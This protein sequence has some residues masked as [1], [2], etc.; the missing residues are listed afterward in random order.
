MVI[1][2]QNLSR[3]S[4]TSIMKAVVSSATPAKLTRRK[5]NKFE[6]EFR[7]IAG[8]GG[9]NSRMKV[10]NVGVDSTVGTRTPRDSTLRET[11]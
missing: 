5:P 7:A 1:P 10:Q 4:H 9:E 6:L 2:S 3:G 8:D 11:A